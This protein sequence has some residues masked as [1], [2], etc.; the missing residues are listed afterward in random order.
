MGAA[1][2]VAGTAGQARGVPPATGCSGLLAAVVRPGALNLRLD[3]NDGCLIW[4]GGAPFG[5]G[6]AD[7][8]TDRLAPALGAPERLRS[9]H[10]QNRQKCRQEEGDYWSPQ[11]MLSVSDR[12]DGLLQYTIRVLHGTLE[13][14][15]D[16][17][18][19]LGPLG[20]GAGLWNAATELMAFFDEHAAVIAGKAFLELGA[21]IGTLGQ[22]ML[23]YTADR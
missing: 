19:V 10:A 18:N 15:S 21:G 12:A 7:M 5:S 20:T 23:C 8:L 11:L 9:L 2:V 13:V 4:P 3:P 16:P 22:V 17:G 1:C 14:I 6:V